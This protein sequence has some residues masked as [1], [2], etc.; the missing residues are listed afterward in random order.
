MF[1]QN[2][3]KYEN[4]LVLRFIHHNDF[5]FISTTVLKDA[6]DNA[7]TVFQLYMPY[8]PSHLG[9]LSCNSFNWKQM[10]DL[11]YFPAEFGIYLNCKT[12]LSGDFRKS[13]QHTSPFSFWYEEITNI[14]QIKIKTS[15][16]KIKY[17]RLASHYTVYNISIQ[18]IFFL[19][20]KIYK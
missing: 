18:F 4:Y 7:V 14:Q 20:L 13:W 11:F 9:L 1:Q 3:K 15:Q 12:E 5:T 2:F 6:V 8:S 10:V 16:N 17:E 19:S